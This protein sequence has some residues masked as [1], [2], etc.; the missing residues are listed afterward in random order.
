M[1]INSF[2][3]YEQVNIAA[4]GASGP[5]GTSAATVDIVAHIGVTASAVNLVFT[6]PNPTDIRN[7]R[8]IR[9]TNKGV[10]SFTMYGLN[11]AAS[12]YATFLWD[13]GAWHTA[14]ATSGTDFWRTPIS[15]GGLP[16]GVTDVQDTIE[17]TGQVIIN[18]GA[19]GDSG[20]TLDDLRG[21]TAGYGQTDGTFVTAIGV[22]PTGKVR[23]SNSLYSTDSRGVNDTPDQ[24]SAGYYIDFKQATT[25]GF[26][27]TATGGPLSGQTYIGLETFR[28]YAQAGDF[29]GGPVIQTTVLD[30]G[31]EYFRVST[32]TTTW[33][34]WTVKT[35]LQSELNLQD[36]L[37]LNGT[38]KVSLNGEVR[39]TTRFIVMT[40]GVTPQEASG[41]HDI[42]I[43]ADGA[44][45]P[46]Q[47][48]GTRTIL[49]PTA[50]QSGATGGIPL[51]AWETLWYRVVRGSGN[52]S[53]ATNFL[54]TPYTTNASTAVPGML[55]EASYPGTHPG[56]WIRVVSRDDGTK[57]KWG[58]GDVVGLGGQFGGGHDLTIAHWTAMKARVQLGGYAYTTF[59]TATPQRFGMTGVIRWID[60]GITTNINSQG[61]V[62]STQAGRAVGIAVIGVNG[63][64]TRAWETVTAADAI[65]KFGGALRGTDAITAASTVV[66]INDNETLYYAPDLP[67]ATP[68]NG[69]T[70]YIAGYSGAVSI[71]IHWLPV[72]SNQTTGGQGTMQ[73]LVGGVQRA[74]RSGDAV[75]FGK[76]D[77]DIDRLHRRMGVTHTGLKYTRWTHTGYFAGAA[78][79]GTIQ[80]G[81]GVLISWDANQMMYGI[82]DGYASWGAQY[83]YI[84]P[85]A[86]GTAIPVA[87]TNGAVAL[88]RVV[89]SIS[90]RTYIPLGQWES[91]WFIP[92]AYTS[93]AGSANGDFVITQ[94]AA[95]HN[96]PAGAVRVA[97]LNAS[98]GVAGTTDGKARVAWADGTVTQPGST[99]ASATPALRVQNDHAQGTGDW[100][101]VTVAGTTGPGMSAV[102]PAV[103]G[104]VGN[105]VAPFTANY[106]YNTIESDPRGQIEI[107]GIISLNNNVAGT[108]NIAFMAGVQVRGQPIVMAQMNRQPDTDAQPIPV[109]LR[110][111]NGT[112][113]GQT[114]VIIQLY[115]NSGSAANDYST[116]GPNGGAQ[117]AGIPQWVNLGPLTLPHS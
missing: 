63:A 70:W 46:V 58:T 78:A 105:Y 37:Q 51:N 34:P 100:R 82:S 13:A 36:L 45:I 26:D 24:Y 109:Q 101:A 27:G 83:V 90:G 48:G 47:G 95:N 93:G 38:A 40:A 1:E 103:A 42:S 14:A 106:R 4:I 94:Y 61:Y 50:G 72:V 64:A 91:L 65:A 68:T 11:I 98:R 57:F 108:A 85:P 111:I 87:H 81:E 116:L 6:L 76:A 102:M 84:N 35:A 5:V 32:S 66:Q 43:P 59:A 55:N 20:L 15:T 9:V 71:P 2:A 8:I 113:N 60:A 39:W 7:G 88:T 89:E 96:V 62:D 86:V 17:R 97:H 80:G 53:V 16:D 25:V 114:G 52:G 104:V 54:I 44:T 3:L 28:R 73:V 31:R 99:L 75:F 67:N 115:G 30:D 92:P 21:M 41:Y 19:A 107:E 69:G 110:F 33:G 49:A 79:N 112:V 74:L 117:A 22:D 29:S 12:N 23:L 56:E 10:N 77:G 18:T